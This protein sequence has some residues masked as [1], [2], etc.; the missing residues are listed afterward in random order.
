MNNYRLKKA[1]FGALAHKIAG[2][3]RQLTELSNKS[4]VR[5][6]KKSKD[7]AIKVIKDLLDITDI[8]AVTGN[9][10]RH[11]ISLD[12]EDFKDAVQ[13][14]AGEIIAVDYIVTRNKVDFSAASLPVVTPDELLVLLSK[15]DESAVTVCYST[16]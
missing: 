10:I 1:I 14:S 5:K 4:I 13:Y 9:E 15:S 3:V 7:I 2:L 12:W 6:E 16:H 11:V 8:A